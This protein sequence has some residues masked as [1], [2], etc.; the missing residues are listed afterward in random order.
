MSL[1][2]GRKL[3]LTASIINILLPV[4]TVILYGFIILSIIASV[5][6]A[7][8]GESVGLPIL[9]SAAILGVFIGLGL[10]GL[11]GFIFFVI[12]MHRLSQYYN[13]PGIFKNMLHG[14]IVAIVGVISLVIVLVAIVVYAIERAKTATTVAPSIISVIGVYLVLFVAFLAILIVSAVFWKRA[15]NKLAEKSGNNN[16]NTAGLLMLLGAAL[17]V[18]GIGGLLS[19]IAWIFAAMGFNSLRPKTPE[20][21]AFPYATP[22]PQFTSPMQ[23]K[24][25]PYCGTE[26]PIDSVYCTN[27][28]QKL[29]E[30]K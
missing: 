3:G 18:V 5:S 4:I 2:P 13:E 30:T 26:N 10:L 29:Q 15:F 8:S 27:C 21:S 9:S 22:Q 19:W 28:G 11:V 24:F 12:S 25:C 23:K 14:I 1:E 6:R 20:T 16:F 7:V 17:S